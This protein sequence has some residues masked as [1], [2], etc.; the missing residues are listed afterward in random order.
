M[1]F[2]DTEAT[3]N[4]GE[5][6][7]WDRCITRRMMHLIC[8]ELLKV[9]KIAANDVKP[10]FS[11]AAFK[12]RVALHFSLERHGRGDLSM[13]IMWKTNTTSSMYSWDEFSPVLLNITENTVPSVARASIFVAPMETG[14]GRPQYNGRTVK[15]T[16]YRN[17]VKEDCLRPV[18]MN[19]LILYRCV[20]W[21]E[22]HE[23]VVPNQKQ[24]KVHHRRFPIGRMGKGL[25]YDVFFEDKQMIEL[26]HGLVKSMKRPSQKE[27]DLKE[28]VEINMSL[29]PS[30]G[31]LAD[32]D[33]F[34]YEDAAEQQMNGYLDTGNYGEAFVFAQMGYVTKRFLVYFFGVRRVAIERMRSGL[35]L[36]KADCAMIAGY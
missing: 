6:S 2:L 33:L 18:Q 3:S 20:L 26:A 10:H 5:A 25:L 4:V 35:G 1:A 24:I 9:E 15:D 36:S 22:R 34:K 19:T 29:W 16:F 12:K 27:K 13:A 7:N 28:S 11:L 8:S 30:S 14:R 32:I 21:L 17:V 23:E 31:G